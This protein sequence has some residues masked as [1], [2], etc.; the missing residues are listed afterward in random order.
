[1]HS[2]LE[3]ERVAQSHGN[4]KLNVIW[5]TSAAENLKAELNSNGFLKSRTAS[6]GCGTAMDPG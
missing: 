4:L 5:G 3:N 6:G 2:Q 1:M